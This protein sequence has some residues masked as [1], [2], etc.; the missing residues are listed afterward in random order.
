MD[1]ENKK[2]VTHG[3]GGNPNAQNTPG[4]QTEKE[5]ANIKT[6]V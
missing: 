6:M 1:K 5:S 4:N 2:S 3:R